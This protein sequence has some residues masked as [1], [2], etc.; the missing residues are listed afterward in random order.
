MVAPYASTYNA[1]TVA[2]TAAVPAAY[3]A[4]PVVAAAPAVY[5]AAPV[6]AAPAA[7][8]VAAP[9]VALLKKKK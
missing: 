2:H 6:V 9:A 3:A 7:R 8:V 1:Y 4:A 5:H